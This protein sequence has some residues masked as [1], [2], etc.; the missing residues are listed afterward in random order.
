MSTEKNSPSIVKLKTLELEISMLIK[1]YKQI[2]NTYNN[3]IRHKNYDAAKNNMEQLNTISNKLDSKMKQAQVM[4][5]DIVKKG[6]EY[7]EIS[8]EK[9]ADIMS[10]AKN[11]NSWAEKLNKIK[12]KTD[13]I[14]G[15]IESTR[16]ESRSNRFQFYFI[17]IA[18][19]IVGLVT[20][21]SMM[22]EETNI[23]ENIIAMAIVTIGIYLLIKKY[24]I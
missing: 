5:D 21:Y 9:D 2:Q 8:R 6:E 17:S 19:F 20:A 23:I 4:I 10:M 22:S 14:E 1:T 18:T 16:I 11:L 12:H 3:N 24:F 13:A 7:Q 15:D